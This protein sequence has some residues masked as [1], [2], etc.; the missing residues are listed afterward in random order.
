MYIKSGPDVLSEGTLENEVLNKTD[1]IV[2]YV[3]SPIA[4]T[5]RSRKK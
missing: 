2:L 3:L 1:F 5:L 4:H